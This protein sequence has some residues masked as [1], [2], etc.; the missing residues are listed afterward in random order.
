LDGVQMSPAELHEFTQVRG[1]YL[2]S[3]L[4]EAINNAEFRALGPDEMD[5]YVKELEKNADETGKYQVWTRR[6]H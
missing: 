6:A 1:A 3:Q 2:K 5:A 4:A